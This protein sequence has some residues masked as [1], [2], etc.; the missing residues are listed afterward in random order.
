[1]P[2]DVL[3]LN[4]ARHAFGLFAMNIFIKINLI[5][6][7]FCGSSITQNYWKQLTKSYGNKPV[8]QWYTSCAFSSPIIW[9]H[10]RM[11]LKCQQQYSIFHQGILTLPSLVSTTQWYQPMAI[12]VTGGIPSTGESIA[13]FWVPWC[14]NCPF[15]L[16]PAVHK[17]PSGGNSVNDT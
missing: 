15:E 6:T 7:N 11:N 16:I 17:T 8:I 12:W 14:P 13:L 10:N 3:P 4:I 1:M 5:G 2:T 9:D